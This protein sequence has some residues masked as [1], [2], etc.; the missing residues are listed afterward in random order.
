VTEWAI[1]PATPADAPAVADVLITARAADPVALPPLVHSPAATRA[2]VTD[3]VVR[4]REVWVVDDGTVVAFLALDDAWLDHLYVRPE[5]AGLGIG[6]ALL[7]LAKVLRPGGF[8]L[9]VFVSNTGAQRFYER[10][11]LVEVERTDGRGNAEQ[12]PD[13]H[14][15]WVP[16]RAPE[17][18]RRVSSSVPRGNRPRPAPGVG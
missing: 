6:S 1:R 16:G 17:P 4:D 12:A 18:S 14:Y 9:W 10:R 5:C 11:G 7:D 2:W 15:A 8:G 3:E 13:I